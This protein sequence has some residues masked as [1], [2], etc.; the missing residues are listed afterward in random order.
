[1]DAKVMQ[2]ICHTVQSSNIL[3]I[4]SVCNVKCVFCS[5]RQNPPGINAIAIPPLDLEEIANLIRFLDKGKKIVIGESASLIME[6]EPFTHPRF[7]QVLDLIRKK[8]P[9]T[10]VQITTNGSFL[11]YKNA[12]KLKEY[13]PLEINLSLNAGSFEMREQLMQDKNSR[14]A[15]EAPVVLKEAGITYHG[16][17]VAMPHITGW[18]ELFFTIEFLSQKGAQTVRV[19]KPGFTKY[20]PSQLIID[21]GTGSLLEEKIARWREGLCPITLEPAVITDLQAEVAGVIFE[22]PAQ[23]AG[24]KSGDIITKINGR[25][26]FSRVEAYSTLKNNGRYELEVERSGRLFT[27]VINISQN[28]SGLVFA[29]DLSLAEIKNINETLAKH[30]AERPLLLASQLG[31]PVLKAALGENAKLQIIPVVNNFFGGNI[32]CAGLLTLDDFRRA[33]LNYLKTNARPDLLVLPST[34]F[35]PWERDLTGRGLWE[36]EEQ[37]GCRCVIC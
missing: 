35:D 11:D 1:M 21:E 7:F 22:S 27:T 13:E 14:I 10:L 2:L 28:K 17:V 16:S 4:T 3:P 6:G 23:K 24:I 32:G 26:P 33:Y 9:Q 19:F 20:A 30:G 8:F 29:Y 12:V 36:L 31:Y 18:D 37:I 5:H 15:C 34:A 25:K